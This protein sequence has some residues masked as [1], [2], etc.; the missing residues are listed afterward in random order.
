MNKIKFIV[1]IVLLLIV[2]G[3]SIN[4]TASA[5]DKIIKELQDKILNNSQLIEA[6]SEKNQQLEIAVNELK[7]EKED[8]NN[9]ISSLKESNDQLTNESKELK[10]MFDTISNSS[11]QKYTITKEQ[12]LGTWNVTYGDELHNKTYTFTAQNTIVDGNWIIYD[13]FSIKVVPRQ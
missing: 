1:G 2:S 4:K 10:K 5:D 11:E 7:K 9:T 12:L 6:L 8:L 3:C 13:N